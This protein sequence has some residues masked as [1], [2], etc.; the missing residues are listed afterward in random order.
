[1]HL[2]E[3]NGFRGTGDRRYERNRRTMCPQDLSLDKRKEA[4]AVC[5]ADGGTVS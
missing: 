3:S 5:R 4:F 2:R 1:M